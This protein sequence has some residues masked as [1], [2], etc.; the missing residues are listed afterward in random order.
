MARRELYP[1]NRARAIPARNDDVRLVAH[2]KQK[3]EWFLLL[4]LVLV[5]GVPLLQTHLEHAIGWHADWGLFG[6]MVAGLCAG[7]AILGYAP[8]SSG[9]FMPHGAIVWRWIEK[10]RAVRKRLLAAAAVSILLGL[11]IDALRS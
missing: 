10:S 9:A 5:A 8:A 6:G 4:L 11:A 1:G 7:I 2:A 3:P